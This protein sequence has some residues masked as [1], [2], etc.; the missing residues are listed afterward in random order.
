MYRSYSVS[1]MPTPI[2]HPPHREERPEKK[3]HRE[4]NEHKEHHIEKKPV[5]QCQEKGGGFLGNLQTDD[6]ILLIVVLALLIDDCDDKMLLA[7]LGFVFLSD[8]L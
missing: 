2:T 7:A 4:H 5:R 6:I 8:F 1:N 3:E